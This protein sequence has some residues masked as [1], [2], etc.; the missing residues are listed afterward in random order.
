MN[1]TVKLSSLGQRL[2]ASLKN[3]RLSAPQGPKSNT[4]ARFA[5]PVTNLIQNSSYHIQL[6]SPGVNGGKG[7]SEKWKL[8]LSPRLGKG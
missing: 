2:R 4:L 3:P 1:K 7:K 8:A 6:H 5:C